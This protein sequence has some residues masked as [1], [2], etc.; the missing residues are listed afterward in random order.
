M[1]R[2]Q[3]QRDA[4]LRELPEHPVDAVAALRVHADRWL[5][6]QDD[7]RVMED[8]AGDVEAPAHA[9]GKLLDR[10]A[11]PIGQPGALERPIDLLRQIRSRESLQP[12][13]RV[14]ILARRQQ[15]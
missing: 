2:R 10:L 14:E 6:E 9:A 13:E 5:V 7:A 11:R 1:V 15:G 8:A 12:A 3:D 4:F